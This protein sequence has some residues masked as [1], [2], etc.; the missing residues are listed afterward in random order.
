M[1]L[2]GLLVLCQ[3]LAEEKLPVMAEL[4]DDVTK[5]F[6][7]LL[8]SWFNRGVSISLAVCPPF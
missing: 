1:F 7:A 5:Y 6:Q 3:D 2:I 4:S 8:T